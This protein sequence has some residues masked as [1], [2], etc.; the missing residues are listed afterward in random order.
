M[1]SYD[2]ARPGN[3]L[4]SEWPHRAEVWLAGFLVPGQIQSCPSMASSQPGLRAPLQVE[5]GM[6]GEPQPSLELGMALQPSP[7]PRTLPPLPS[8][9]APLSR[10]WAGAAAFTGDKPGTWRA[11]PQVHRPFLQAPGLEPACGHHCPRVAGGGLAMHATGPLH[12][13]RACVTCV[14]SQH[15]YFVPDSC[16]PGWPPDPAPG[17]LTCRLPTGPSPSRPAPQGNSLELLLWLGPWKEP[18]V[19][20]G[21]RGPLGPRHGSVRPWLVLSVGLG[22][23]PGS[24][25]GDPSLLLGEILALAWTS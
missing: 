1:E 12:L 4:R 17:Q 13:S 3:L 5:V 7:W 23:V 21:K 20:D 15:S 18:G 11:C 8:D 22:A 10:L 9:P 19:W 25:R 2:Q 24:A 6:M 16:A 14:L